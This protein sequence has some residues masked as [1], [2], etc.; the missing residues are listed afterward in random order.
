MEIKVV[1]KGD[2]LILRAYCP[3]KLGTTI[4][5]YSRVTLG[6]LLYGSPGVWVCDAPGCGCLTHIHDGE[7]I[8][9]SS[10]SRYGDHRSWN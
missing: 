4:L 5:A 10:C 2:K 9:R 6:E 1:P 3:A 7:T 8:G